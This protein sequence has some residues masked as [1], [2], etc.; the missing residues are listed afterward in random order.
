MN[1]KEHVEY[2]HN[3]RAFGCK[4]CEVLCMLLHEYALNTQKHSTNTHKLYC[5]FYVY[6]IGKF[7]KSE[8]RLVDARRQEGIESDCLWVRF[9]SVLWS[10]GRRKCTHRHFCSKRI[11]AIHLCV[12][13]IHLDFNILDYFPFYLCFVMSFPSSFKYELKLLCNTTNEV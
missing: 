3:R 2:L 9:G 8:S 4:K 6:R 5:F 7:M 13:D 12:S 11:Y 10:C 1:G